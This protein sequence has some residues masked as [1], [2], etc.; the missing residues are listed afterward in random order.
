MNI[1][2][3][4]TWRNRAGAQLHVASISNG[5]AMMTLNEFDP[6]GLVYAVDM[7]GN[8]LF[9][10]DRDG[11]LVARVPRIYVAGPMTGLPKQNFPVFHAA[12]AML[13]GKGAH[14]ENPAEIVMPPDADWYDCMR[15]D[16]PRLLTCDTLFL[17]PGWE[18]SRGANVE[19]KLAQDLGMTIIYP[20]E[21]PA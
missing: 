3:G 14:V 20:S 16:I 6:T 12:A 15:R 2:Q 13:R 19:Y 9:Q 7:N 10:P 21:Q 4:Q 1:K 17:L 5:R 11:D 18:A 8:A